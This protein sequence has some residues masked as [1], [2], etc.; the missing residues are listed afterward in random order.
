[1]GRRSKATKTDAIGLFP[2]ARVVRGFDWRWGTQD[3][4]TATTSAA[5]CSASTTNTDG[6][7]TQMANPLLLPPHASSSSS[8]VSTHPDDLAATTATP[9]QGRIIER[10]DWFQWAPKSAVAVAWDSGAYNVYRV[11]YL[12]MV[13]LKAVRP[14]K[15][16][17]VHFV[18]IFCC[19]GVA[20]VCR[21]GNL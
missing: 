20:C 8:S 4:A 2:R 15:G 18:L 12:G 3:C 6:V 21:S 5:S 9:C 13:D 19:A 16:I 14:A 17:R 11:G 10:R 7:V 1:M